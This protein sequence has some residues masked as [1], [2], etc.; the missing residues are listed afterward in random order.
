MK[1][2]R[3][4]DVVAGS[5]EFTTEEPEFG[6]EEEVE[7]EEAADVT[8]PLGPGVTRLMCEADATK[9]IDVPGCIAYASQ[10]I[11]LARTSVS[12]CNEDGCPTA[13]DVSIQQ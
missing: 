6:A 12:K 8:E 4:K 5:I 2:S 1:F 3:P 7:E 11:N 9:L 13:G 10:I